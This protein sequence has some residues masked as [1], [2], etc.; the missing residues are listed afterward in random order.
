[1]QFD[2]QNHVFYRHEGGEGVI[3][4]EDALSF[5][6]DIASA[7]DF[8]HLKRVVHRDIKPA[9]IL[10]CTMQESEGCGT[11]N[12]KMRAILSDFSSSHYFESD[13]P[14]GKLRSTE[15][16]YAFFSPEVC[17]GDWFDAYAVDIWALGVTMFVAVFGRFPF[18][19]TDSA[20]FF[21]KI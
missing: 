14:N 21:D 10:T 20:E 8:I 9:N 13:K 11:N 17:A 5:A 16:T 2:R 3:R 19:A 7:I 1:M 15:G 4:L 18:C 6:L 12:N